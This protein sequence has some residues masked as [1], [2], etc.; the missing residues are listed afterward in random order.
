M[1]RCVNSPQHLL[2]KVRPFPPM[3]AI[4]FEYC[5][6]QAFGSLPLSPK[7]IP[8][9]QY[10]CYLN[11]RLD[12]SLSAP[13]SSLVAFVSRKSPLTPINLVLS[14]LDT[15]SHLENVMCDPPMSMPV[16]I[17][18]LSFHPLQT[19]RSALIPSQHLVHTLKHRVRTRCRPHVSIKVRGGHNKSLK[20]LEGLRRQN[21]LPGVTNSSI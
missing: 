1:R 21:R 11:E 15:V 12:L 13:P 5:L 9:S 17:S 3:N 20:L 6:T 4:D 16:A 7:H 8:F 18:I 10:G 2:H 14:T 19:S